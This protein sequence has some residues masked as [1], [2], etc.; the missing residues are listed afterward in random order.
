[1][2]RVRE[3]ARHTLRL[4]GVRLTYEAR[5]ERPPEAP[6]VWRRALGTADL[7]ARRTDVRVSAG[8]AASDLLSTA[9]H[10]VA[11]RHPWA[12]RDDELVDLDTGFKDSTGHSVYV[13]GGVFLSHPHTRRWFHTDG[14]VA[15]RRRRRSDPLWIL[16]VLRWA[17]EAS[18]VGSD[19]AG[20]DVCERFSFHVDLALHSENVE[21][22]PKSLTGPPH[23]VGEVSIDHEGRIRRA[24]WHEIPRR[25]T[26]QRRRS[27]GASERSELWMT[28]EL[29]DYGVEV[30]IDEPEVSPSSV[31]SLKVVSEL[32]TGL[33]RRK[34]QYERDRREADT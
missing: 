12:L 20:G 21:V 31:S 7:A 33:W 19:D 28:L 17:D 15:S 25:R 26:R 6:K 16:E 4:P 5:S 9:A 22:G 32:A 3:A 30:S 13:G 29:W 18:V 8:P 24:S 27:A 34:R 10:H 1:V 14:D 2:D 23:V 11:E